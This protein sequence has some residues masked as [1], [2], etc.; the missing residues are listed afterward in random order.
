MLKGKTVVLGVSGS[1]AAY[2]IANLASMLVKLG[3]DVHV[4][5]TKNATYFINPITFETI[6]SNKCIVDTF[7]RNFEFNVEHVSLAKKADIFMVT[8]ATANIIAKIANG[9]ADDMLSTTFLAA[10]CKKIVVPTMNTNM[11]LNPIT[12]SNINKLKEY[13]IEVINPSVGHLACGDNGIGKMPDEGLLLDYIIKNIAFNHDLK[14]KKVL[15]SAGPTIEKI[16]PVRYITNHSTGK[17]G[18]AL[19]KIASLRGANVTLVSGKT[20]LKAF[21]DIN[22][23]NVVSASQMYDEITKIYDYFDIVI[24]SSA[25]ADYTPITYVDQKIKKAGDN[26]EIKLTRTK[27]ILKYLGENKKNQILVG[28]SMETNNLIENSKKK[29]ESKNADLICANCLNDDKA[30]FGYDTNKVTLITKKDIKELELLTKE[31]VSIK[32]LDCVKEM[33]K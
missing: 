28:F 27:D 33:I 15:I 6:T 17:M 11:Y 19:A 20:N 30:G 18:Y 8:P 16:D 31:E 13:N 7:D 22:L 9:L 32:I 12:Q 10:T 1:I 14:G 21:Y 5:M 26:L 4:I 3:A 23:I 29:L 24:M 2:K 25:V